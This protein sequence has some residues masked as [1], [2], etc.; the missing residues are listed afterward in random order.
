MLSS[1]GLQNY[2]VPFKISVGGE[3]KVRNSPRLRSKRLAISLAS[4][5]LEILNLLLLFSFNKP[6]L[7]YF[8]L[9]NIKDSLF[10]R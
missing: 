3:R 4:G 10:E 8:I 9:K 6:W 2:L 7:W 5:Y 1:V